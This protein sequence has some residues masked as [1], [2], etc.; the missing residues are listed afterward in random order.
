MAGYVGCTDLP[1]VHFLPELLHLYPEAKVVLVT[2][3]PD[4]WLA[5]ILPIARNSLRWWLKLAVWPVP[6]W[7]WFPSL[8]WWFS[9]S[10]RLARGVEPGEPDR[11]G[12]SKGKSAEDL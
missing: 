3:D 5:S 8:V 1:P 11:E 6:G 7:R 2:R 9:E 10:S 4:R 12:L